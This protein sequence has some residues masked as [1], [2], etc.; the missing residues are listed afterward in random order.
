MN[1]N[2]LQYFRAVYEKR[3][4]SAAAKA[5]PMTHQGLSQ[6]L[7][8]LES[9]LG[10]PLFDSSESFVKNPT[11]YADVL[12]EFSSKVDTLRESLTRDFE[13]ID[14][15][16]RD[17][18]RLV[19]ATGVFGFLGAS[20]FDLFTKQFPN[21]NLTRTE[22]PDFLCDDELKKGNFNVAITVYPF[23]DEFETLPLYLADRMVWVNIADSLACREQLEI[24]DLAGYS[25]ATMGEFYK[26]YSDL[27]A[28]LDKHDIILKKMELASEMVWLLHFA[29]EPGRASFTVPHI[30][31]FLSD[32]PEIVSIPIQDIPWGFGISWRN[33]YK[34]N[35]LEEEFVRFC[36]EYVRRKP[37]PF[38][39]LNFS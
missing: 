37:L 33:G 8:N 5:L 11:K 4:L 15:L 14:S 9:E 36:V 2:Q 23:D 20:F 26:N 38:S 6:A 32:D 25:V 34:P 16:L 29:A 18:L 22:L 31:E 17:E 27:K 28:T 21:T 7:S 1:L 24:K 10:V 12:Y 19:A 39:L 30:A 3:S 35:E 13:S